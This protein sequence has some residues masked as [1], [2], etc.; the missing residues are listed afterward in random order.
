MSD[1]V[2]TPLSFVQKLAKDNRHKLHYQKSCFNTRKK[3]KTFILQVV[4]HWNRLSKEVM[5]C[6]CVETRHSFEKSD[7]SDPT[8]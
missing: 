8:L 5:E 7:V 1:M 6:S 3:T 2:E 4:K